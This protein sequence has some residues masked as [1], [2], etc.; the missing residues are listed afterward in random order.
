V[1]EG[2]S[3]P[4]LGG[5]DGNWVSK[6]TG[7]NPEALSGNAPVLWTADIG[8]GYSNV[9]IHGNRLYAM[10]SDSAKQTITCLDAATGKV[11]WKYSKR[12]L[13]KTPQSTPTIDGDVVYTLSSDG[14]LN[15]FHTRNGKVKWSMHLVSDYDVLL[16]RYGFSGSPVVEGNL[17]LITC[18]AYGITLDKET[19]K[20]AW[21]SP[22][23]DPNLACRSMI[24][25]YATPVVYT[26]GDERY[27]LFSAGQP[28]DF[29]PHPEP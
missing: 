13:G 29:L 7:W 6:E 24:D 28:I 12:L 3:W 1:E 17:L 8:D 5:P 22:I 10:G 9:A 4:R 18:N 25:A 20:V 19:G 14:L 21:K 11:R 15:C 16:P 23:E 26:H 27:L 2:Y